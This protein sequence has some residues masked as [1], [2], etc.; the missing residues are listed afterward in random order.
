MSSKRTTGRWPELAI[1]ESNARRAPGVLADLSG[2]YPLET[3]AGALSGGK[4][5][6]ALGWCF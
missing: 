4:H 1:A 3:P 6:L 5:A 2:D